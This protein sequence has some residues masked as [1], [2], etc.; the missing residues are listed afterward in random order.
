MTQMGLNERFEQWL[1]THFTYI[2]ER[3]ADADNRM[4]VVSWSVKLSFTYVSF[5]VSQ[6]LPGP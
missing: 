5:I 6:G 3:S 2:S 1:K 4:L